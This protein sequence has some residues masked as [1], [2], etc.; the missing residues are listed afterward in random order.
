MKTLI[1]GHR[2]PD[3][4]QWQQFLIVEGLLTTGA[5]GIFGEK[6]ATATRAFQEKERLTPDARVG[7]LTLARAQARGLKVYRPLKDGELNAGLI[8]EAKRILNAHWQD[9]FGSE[10]PFEFAGASYLGRIEQHYHPPGG[11]RR[12]WGYHP[13]VTLLVRVGEPAQEEIFDEDAQEG[14]GDVAPSPTPPEGPSGAKR[15]TLS[16]RSRERLRGVRPELVK[17]IERAI[18]ITDIDFLVVE[19]LRS[20]ERQRE[21]VRLGA[22]QTL[23]SRHL[24]GHAVDI[25]PIFANTVSWHWPHFEQ[26]ARFVKLA[27]SEVN[28][29]AEWGGDW[30]SFRDGPH[31][32]LPWKE[33]PRG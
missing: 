19:G 18:E 1:Q 15:F 25:A 16:A 9:P 33:F 2:G 10:F 22:S 32:Q 13:G 31:W 12:P 17:L 8:A 28:V 7:K 11:P 30:T 23:N 6:T 3:V 4:A 14:D 5:D 26:L 27:A 21:L 29:N 24:T 20:I